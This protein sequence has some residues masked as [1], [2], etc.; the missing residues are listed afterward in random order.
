MTE[1]LYDLDSYVTEFNCKVTEL[2]NCEDKL[3]VVTDRTA[4]FPEGGGQTSDV[5]YL[6]NA[7]VEHV[8]IECGKIKHYVE[9]CVENLQKFRVGAVL[10]GKIDMK[11]RFSDMQQH[12]GEHIFSGIVH[13]LY[14]YDN[15]GFHLGS[16]VVTVDFN[17]SLDYDDVCKVERLVNNAIWDDLEVRVFYPTEQEINSID[18]RSKK[19]I[20]DALRL[21]EIPGVDMC[22][23]CAPH[24]KRT[25]EIGIFE[26]VSFEKYKGGTR[27]SILCGERAL[28]DI[29]RKLDENHKV[30]NLLSAKETQTAEMV[31]KLKDDNANLNFQLQGAKLEL[32]KYKAES[33]EPQ[34]RIIVFFDTTDV[35]MLRE[36]ANLISEKAGEFAAV[37]AGDGEYKYVIISKTDFDV[38]SLCKKLNSAFNGRGG[39]R[40]GIVQGSISGGRDEIEAALFNSVEFEEWSEKMRN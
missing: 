7:Y 17:G 15:V 25:G 13:S 2:Y 23:C 35:N 4:F 9:N 40:G 22:A 12:T 38:N 29:R 6:E 21:V 37:F 34:K 11:K 28:C 3:I 30:S 39:G 27:L 32:L 5:G 1:K 24:V 18:Y 33:V 36:F 16:E 8:E 19:E 10:H 26:I 20:N 31:Q 14:G